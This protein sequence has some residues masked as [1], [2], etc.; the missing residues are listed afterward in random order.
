M[1]VKNQT[2][3]ITGASGRIGSVVSNLILNNNC[4]AILVDINLMKLKKLVAKFDNKKYIISNIDINNQKNFDILIKKS[5]K[6]FKRIDAAVNCAY[7][8]TKNWG[9]VKFEDKKYL[10]IAEDLKLQLAGPIIICQKLFKVFQKQKKG[11]IILISSIMGFNAPKFETYIGTKMSSSIEYGAIKAG[12]ISAMKYLAKYS[13]N[14]N[15]RVNCISPGGILDNQP[16]VFI[17][18]YK[19][20]CNSKGLID[21]K[22]LEPAFKYL[23]DQNNKYV[24]G[25][26]IIVDDGWSN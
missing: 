7:P 8:S 24:T 3:L 9:K 15:I 5:L 19:K 20:I 18:K 23:L 13:K 10:D 6:K 4:N 22:D 12:I 11:N 26:N 16:Q 1:S 2:I 21:G 14:K 17:K 25:Q